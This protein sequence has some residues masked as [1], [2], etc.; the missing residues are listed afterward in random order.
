M[1]DR[2]VRLAADLPPVPP[3]LEV[4]QQAITRWRRPS[5]V[6]V[7]AALP[8]QLDPNLNFVEVLDGGSFSVPTQTVSWTLSAVAPGASIVKRFRASADTP[9]PNGIVISNQGTFLVEVWR[10]ARA[11]LLKSYFSN[12]V[13]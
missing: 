12:E 13:G 9:L 10:G 7:N 8:D 6:V 4:K 11:P 5:T 1:T 2:D 3:M